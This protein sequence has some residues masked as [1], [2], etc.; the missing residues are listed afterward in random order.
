MLSRLS[1]FSFR[2]LLGATIVAWGCVCGTSARAQA[3]VVNGG[4]EAHS[5]LPN[6]SGQF[7]L[8][9]GWA[10]GGGAEGMPD[11]YHQ[12]GTNGGDLPQTPLAKVSAFKG[13]AIAG[14]VASLSPL[15]PQA[16]SAR[17]VGG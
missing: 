8:V 16:E 14:F 5:M 11:Y 2:A 15:Q 17:R 4:F 7:H 1:P 3:D 9:D 6:A 13:R 10:H 12:F